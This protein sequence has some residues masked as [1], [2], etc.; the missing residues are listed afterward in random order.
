MWRPPHPRHRALKP[1]TPV[2]PAPNRARSSLL[3]RAPG[4]LHWLPDCKE[5]PSQRAQAAGRSWVSLWFSASAKPRPSCPARTHGAVALVHR[6][7]HPF[8]SHV[9]KLV[10]NF[11]ID[12][13][14]NKPHAFARVVHAFLVGDH[15]GPPCRRERDWSLSAQRL[16]LAFAL[17]SASFM[18]QGHVV[19]TAERCSGA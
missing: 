11:L 18:M 19:A 10:S 14:A 17:T 4:P 2:A 1:L 9:E 13:Q 12:C 7:G 6:S 8:A 3:G 5:P 16:G 15:G